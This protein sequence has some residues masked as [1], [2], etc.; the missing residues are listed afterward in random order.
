MDKRL[1]HMPY[2]HNRI[3]R[4]NWFKC[5][6]ALRMHSALA[7]SHP[8]VECN[9]PHIQ[10]AVVALIAPGNIGIGCA[11]W[12]R[13]S[14][15]AQQ[16]CAAAAAASAANE[17]RMFAA[18]SFLISQHNCALVAAYCDAMQCACSALP[19]LDSVPR[20]LGHRDGCE[21]NAAVSNA[22]LAGRIRPRR[23]CVFDDR[24]LG[25]I[26]R[27]CGHAII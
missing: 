25:G 3:G 9:Y 12:R 17:L 21:A 16:L 11:R 14:E 4:L 10:P 22:G 24:R 2:V 27:I 19:T 18:E 8:P 13:P 20:L 6:C 15:R 23:R 1:M 26:W 7:F 5:T